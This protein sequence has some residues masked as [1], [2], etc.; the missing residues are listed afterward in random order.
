MKTI[1]QNISPIEKR[2]LE[3][4][5]RMAAKGAQ[6]SAKAR[7]K[8][9][10]RA[11]MSS[12]TAAKKLI[13]DVTEKVVVEIFN[14]MELEE[15]KRDNK[16]AWYDVLLDTNL[17]VVAEMALIEA[18]DGAGRT[19]NRNSMLIPM[20]L[21]LKAARFTVAMGRSSKGRNTLAT[22]E[23]KATK[24]HQRF[25]EQQNYIQKMA[26]GRART[27]RNGLKACCGTLEVSFWTA[28]LCR[29]P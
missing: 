7:T 27:L 5:Q 26:N 1:E 28:F 16:C 15:T 20:G 9:I 10:R 3:L 13:E 8:Q 19:A 18:M 2:E 12:T 29:R 17:Y 23:S 11:G 14:R 25:S 6:R 24:Y 22:L 4:E 21:A